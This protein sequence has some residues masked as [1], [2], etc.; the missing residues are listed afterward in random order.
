MW[1]AGDIGRPKRAARRAA[2]LRRAAEQQQRVRLGDRPRRDLHG[3]AAVLERLAGPRL[4]HHVD[5]L[6]HERAAVRPV[7][8]VGGVLLGPV[9]D[10]GDDA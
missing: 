7:L 10:A 9:A 3:G 5:R 1:A 2:G 6:V 4:E 8:A